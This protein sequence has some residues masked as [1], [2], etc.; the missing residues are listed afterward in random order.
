MLLQVNAKWLLDC[1]KFNEW[2][3][4]LDYVVILTGSSHE[5]TAPYLGEC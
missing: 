4:E 5:F 3:N 2:M 1:E